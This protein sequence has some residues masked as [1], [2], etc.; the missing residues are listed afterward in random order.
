MGTISLGVDLAK[1]VFAVCEVDG[2]ARVVRRREFKRG[3]F[4]LHLAQLPGTAVAMEVC[5][6]A[7]QWARRCLEFGLVP[8]LIGRSWYARFAR[9]HWPRTIPTMPRR[10]PP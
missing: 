3:A 9:I 4:A 1:C 7:H 10:L 6:G 2:A 8:R 5:I